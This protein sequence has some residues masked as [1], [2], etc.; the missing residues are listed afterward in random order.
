[1]ATELADVP[2]HLVSPRGAVVRRTAPISSATL[3][4]AALAVIAALYLGV[5][6][7]GRQ[8][9]LFLVG[10]TTAG[11]QVLRARRSEIEA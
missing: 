10:V 1:M 6:V 7:S 3:V 11:L 4:A 5:T 2:I 8:A 9:V